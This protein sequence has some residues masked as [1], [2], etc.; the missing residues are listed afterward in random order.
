MECDAMPADNSNG[1]R[2]DSGKQPGRSIPVVT[3]R[4][5]ILSKVRKQRYEARGT[6]LSSAAS[7]SNAAEKS[8][9]KTTALRFVGIVLSDHVREASLWRATN[10]WNALTTLELVQVSIAYGSSFTTQSLVRSLLTQGSGTLTIVRVSHCQLNDDTALDLAHCLAT[11]PFLPKL[12]RLDVSHNQITD[13]GAAALSNAL[14]APG[15]TELLELDMS[16]NRLT[17]TGMRLLAQAI[18][19]FTCLR[20][21]R[22]K[23]PELLIPA[24]LMVQFSLAMEQN[25]V[26]E[27]LSVGSEL[28]DGTTSSVSLADVAM[29]LDVVDDLLRYCWQEPAYTNATNRIRFHLRLNHIGLRDLVKADRFNWDTLVVAIDAMDSDLLRT[30]AWFRV[31]SL[32]PDLLFMQA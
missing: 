23:D 31:L 11:E 21:L 5:A 27:T 2:N 14:M 3:L 13:R 28:L 25:F 22:L 8:R 16:N 17:L 20:V 32:R 29:G 10:S 1:N 30:E 9:T 24:S 4:S 19:A 18:P 6:T 7:E 12:R 15:C 26:I